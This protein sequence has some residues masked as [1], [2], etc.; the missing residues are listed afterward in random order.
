MKK[1]LIVLLLISIQLDAGIIKRYKQVIV[2]GNRS[3]TQQEILSQG[4]IISRDNYFY[5]DLDLL[6][7]SLRKNTVVLNFKITEERDILRIKI[8][9]NIINYSLA[10]V[11][12]SDMRL[13]EIDNNYSI[14]TVDRIPAG[15]NPLVI[16]SISDLKGKL[17]SKR[18]ID[19][20][21]TLDKV[22]NL[23]IWGEIDEI[24]ARRNDVFSVKMKNRGIR[25]NI[26]QDYNS[27]VKLNLLIGYFD[28]IG[29]YPKKINF[30][31]NVVVI[32]KD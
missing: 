10:I 16:I 13:C 15:N 24:D 22:K 20:F 28:S 9:E 3:L 18:A 32:K 31:K 19:I 12:K 7:N 25:V 11:R 5:A 8:N 29:Y 14:I 1:I 23:A 2:E 17:F 21:M 26:E 30:Y 27:F 4:K 6:N